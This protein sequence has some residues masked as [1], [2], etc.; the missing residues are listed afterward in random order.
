M[1]KEKI[2]QTLAGILLFSVFG[3]G[4]APQTVLNNWLLSPELKYTA[5]S[6]SVVDL[7]SGRSLAQTEPM[8]SLTP[9]SILKVITTATA[10]EVF[11]P[12]YQFK[13]SLVAGGEI[14]ND[15]LF[16]D[17]RIV[18]GGDPTLGSAY[19]L[20][21]RDFGNAWI[22]ALKQNHIRVI[23]GR[24]VADAGI[25]D[26]F[27]PGTWVWE[28]LGNYYGAG[29]CGLSVFDNQY[30]VHLQSPAEADQPAKIIS[31]QPEVPGLVLKN[32]VLS[33]DINSDQAYIFGNPEDQNRV[34]RGTIPKG[35]TDFVVKGAMP[36]PP[37][38]LAH[39]FE[40][41]LSDG[42]VQVKHEI[43]SD[44]SNQDKRVIAETIS[45]A[46]SEIIK[47]TNHESVNL[48]AEHLLKHLAWQKSGFGTTD[49]GTKIVVDFWR[50]KGIDVGGLFM[51][52]GSGLSRFD[53]VTA[54]TMTQ[55]LAYMKTR[56]TFAGVFTQSLPAVGDGTLVVFK[57]TGFPENTLRAKSGS[58]TRVRCY[59]GYLET[60][61]EKTLAF[62][63]MLNNFTCSQ[64]AAV[65]KIGELLASLREDY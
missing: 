41:K 27:I 45:P 3:Y 51:S 8:I 31:I 53:A 49:E 5:A 64:S 60:S 62:T 65:R 48:F 55:I 32:E 16:G 43:R 57:N 17:L 22:D 63:V 28:D 6:V 26:R 34:I 56:S 39:E 10:L 38:F 9:A 40:R 25:Y 20:E 19:F 14:K 4:Q 29:A 47:V 59:A 52:D 54:Q 42:G 1:I 18:G 11:G 61:S 21:S 15:T 58:M 37:A 50:E 36:D 35:R 30:E 33:S 23:T 7:S 44:K 46:L 13:T 2:V 12:D 24:V